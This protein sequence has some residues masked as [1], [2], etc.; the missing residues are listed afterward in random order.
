MG[1][2]SIIEDP[3]GNSLPEDGRV[4]SRQRYFDS[5][6]QEQKRPVFPLVH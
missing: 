2:K 4:D 5:G 3:K 1:E 6:Y